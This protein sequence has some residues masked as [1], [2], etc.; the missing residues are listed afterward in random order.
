VFATDQIIAGDTDD[1]TTAITDVLVLS[2]TSSGGV[3]NNLGVGI[4][5]H[6]EDASDMNE[7]ARLDTVLIDMTDGSEDA[8]FTIKTIAGGSIV[9]SSIST[10]VTGLATQPNTIATTATSGSLT[11][12]GGMGVALQLYTGGIME[13]LSEEDAGTGTS[14]SLLV[15]GGA[16]VAKSMFAGSSIASIPLIEWTVTLN[17]QTITKS[18][19]VSVTQGSLTPGVLLQDLTGNGMT[20]ITFSGSLGDVWL[21]TANIVVDGVT[22][23]ATNLQSSNA[24]QEW[25]ATIATQ[26]ISKTVGATVT[27]GSFTGTLKEALTGAGMTSI[28]FYGTLGQEWVAGT[29]IALTG[30]TGAD[31][32][33]S[34]G[35]VASILALHA[36]TSSITGA[37]LTAGGLGVAKRFY[38]SGGLYVEANTAATSPAHGS[39]G[40]VGGAGF[41]L[42]VYA[43][44]SIVAEGTTNSVSPTTGSLL[45]AGGLGVAKNKY[46]NTAAIA[47][48][49]QLSTNYNQGSLVTAGGVGVSQSIFTGGQAVF[50]INNP[51]SVADGHNS[52]KDVMRLGHTLTSGAAA[53]GIG[54]GIS[55]AVDALAGLAER[56]RI[57]TT[58][59]TATNGAEDSTMTFKGMAVGNMVT[60][61]TITDSTKF[62]ANPTTVERFQQ[63]FVFLCLG[64]CCCCCC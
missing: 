33:V 40:A 60:S 42:S 46:V 62:A 3:A 21:H 39:V 59:N 8:S 47:A 52:V 34:G 15:A 41:A 61:F 27:Q 7:V 64:C 1:S 14:G 4:S 6:V 30:G 28:V 25:T 22:V 37:L 2:H 50:G 9:A 13:V 44:A 54:V 5:V 10:G 58:Y 24:Q 31:V 43:G 38:T 26:S 18:A 12:G 35:D 57:E 19:G 17:P 32:T 36:S 11:T 49:A 53:N 63:F 55:V 51:A 48:S 45:T 29:A 23:T 20:S 16:S 56:F